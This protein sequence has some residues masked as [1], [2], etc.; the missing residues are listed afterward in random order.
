MDLATGDVEFRLVFGVSPAEIEGLEGRVDGERIRF[1]L[2][3]RGRFDLAAGR[4]RSTSDLLTVPD[5]P[6]QGLTI[7]NCIDKIFAYESTTY[8][9]TVALGV[10]VLGGPFAPSKDVPPGQAPKEVWICPGTPIE[11]VWGSTGAD[12]VEIDPDV[13]EVATDGRQTIPDPT[14]LNR[15]LHQA[16][17]HSTTYVA[18][19]TPLGAAEDHVTV[20]VIGPGGEEF[21]Q[22]ATYV[23]GSRYWVAQLPPHTYDPRIKV[24]AVVIDSGRS[25][26]VTHPSWRVDHLYSGQGPVGTPIPSLNQRTLTG[27]IHPLPGEY[28]FTPMPPGVSLPT[29]EQKRHV[30]FR[31]FVE[32]CGD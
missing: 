25:D 15:R 26:S 22:K 14:S 32:S 2:T 5:G 10:W 11:L 27:D 6:F 31:L 18:V 19:T 24:H 4:Y 1:A 3:E 7:T 17:Q 30:Y 23:D 21:P 8:T 28:R 16:R 13:G 20:N 9:T 29:G 12:G